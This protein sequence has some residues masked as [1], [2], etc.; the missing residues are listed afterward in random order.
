MKTI[1]I[2]DKDYKVKFSLRALLIYEKISGKPF[3]AITDITDEMV[4]LFSAML[5]ADSDLDMD[6]DQFLDA[7]DEDLS[8]LEQFHKLLIEDAKRRK[9]FAEDSEGDSKKK[10]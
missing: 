4:Y 7:I 10:S 1:R 5:A 2:N 3:T 8:V 9:V 6:F